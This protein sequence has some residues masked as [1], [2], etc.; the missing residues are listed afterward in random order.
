LG[1]YDAQEAIKMVSKPPNPEDAIYEAAESDKIPPKPNFWMLKVFLKKRKVNLGLYTSDVWLQKYEQA[2]AHLQEI[3]DD[4]ES[5]SQ[6][7]DKPGQ[8][9][10]EK[11]PEW[12]KTIDTS[13]GKDDAE[14]ID[15]AYHS[16]CSADQVRCTLRGTRSRHHI[17]F[18]NRIIDLSA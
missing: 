16:E 2:C 8:S 18:A 6:S 3:E 7:Q 14:E 10:G 11:G 4:A 13:S 1:N 15:S 12:P 17:D 5:V 9:A